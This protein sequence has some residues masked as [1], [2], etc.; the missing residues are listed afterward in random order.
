MDEAQLIALVEKALSLH[1]TTGCLFYAEGSLERR[2]RKELTQVGPLPAIKKLLV[3]H[4]RNAGTVECRRETRVEYQNHR[5]F[6][7]R[8][9]VPV[10]GSPMPLFFELELTDDD[11]DFPSV[12]ILNVHF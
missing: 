12:A 11:P 10:A 6:W 5:E 1:G 8:V 9:L 4:V 3:D 2:L 7:F